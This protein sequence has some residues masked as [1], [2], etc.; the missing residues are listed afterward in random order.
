MPP[1]RTTPLLLLLIAAAVTAAFAAAAGAH[2]NPAPQQATSPPPARLVFPVVGPTRFS[3][4]F[5]AA[6][7]RGGHQGNDVLAVRGAPV[8]AVEAGNV[9]LWTRSPGAGCMLYL[10]GRSGTTYLYVHLNNDLTRGNDNRGSCVDGVAYAPALR[11]GQ[12]VRAGELLG[13]V[14]DSGDANGLHPHLHFELHP[15]G[16]AAISPYRWL[17]DARH[18]TAAVPTTP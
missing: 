1:H 8:V 17:R 18:L 7:G 4:D 10:Y 14:G 3:D 5:G 6:R 13:Y 16:R 9:E 11:D 2:N 12:H 15:G